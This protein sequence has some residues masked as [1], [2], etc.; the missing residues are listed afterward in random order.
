MTVNGLPGHKDRPEI[1]LVNP[2][3]YDFAAYDFW[4]KPAGLLYLASI[5][6][7]RG[8]NVSYIDC[9]DRFH[10][11]MPKT[12]PHTGNGRGPYL[13]TGLPKPE[14]LADV[15]RNFSRYGIKK[16]WFL[17][18]LQAVPEPD[19]ILVTSLMTYW[20]PGVKETIKIIKETFPK[21]PLVLGGIYA[22]LCYSHALQHSG[23]DTVIKGQ[24][25]KELLELT[26]NLTGFRHAAEKEALQFNADIPDTY[27]YPAF[28]LQRRINYVP[29]VTSKGCPFAC[30]Y[31]ASHFLNPEFKQRSPASVVQ[32]IEYW[33]Q[34]YGVKNFVFYDDALLVD[35]AKHAEPMLE[36]IIKKGYDICFHTPNALHVREITATT[37][38]LM[39][40]AGFKTLRLGL[41]T[42]LFENRT[43]I[44][45]KVTE[46]DFKKAVTC[47]KNAG[48]K[49]ENTGAY[50]LA[51]LPGQTI[52]SVK[53]SIKTVKQTGITPVIAY[54]T[55][56]P[57]TG[58]WPEA[59]ASSRYD[60]EADPIFTN[61][62][63]LPCRPDPFS[64]KIFSSFK[65]LVS[66]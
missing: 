15:D 39:F 41:E 36:G 63:I 31:C 3:I 48:F 1:L 35:S 57:H 23:A 50:L 52:D 10:P 30:S 61:N 62:A 22:T 19:I 16:K 60:L 26:E 34:T 33:H 14:G 42:T 55:P 8:F 7:Q 44:D 53:A 66:A 64:W 18:D 25:I 4:A 17:E 40:K 9:L 13:K 28:D 59:V 24:G 21:T 54:Y 47:L 2:W 11:C 6:R 51:G 5:L 46:K 27:P 38:A 20:Y 29:L 65:K 12:N 32:E 56:I 45:H 43:S 37:A 49:R 58:M